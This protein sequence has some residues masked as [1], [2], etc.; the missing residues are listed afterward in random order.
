MNAINRSTVILAA[1]VLTGASYGQATSNYT[2]TR[3][4]VRDNPGVLGQSYGDLNYS[5]VDFRHSAA[6]AYDLGASANLPIAPGIDAGLG[7]QYYRQSDSYDP[8]A[9]RSYD[10]R[11]HM[12][13]ANANFFAPTRGAKP[14]IGGLVGYEWTH[15]SLRRLRTYDNQWV[16]GA[17]GG[18]E[19]PVGLFAF[20]PHVGYTDTMHSGSTGSWHYGAEAHHWFSET[21][22]AYV[23][24]TFHDPNRNG[25]P[26]AWTYTAGLRM[27]Y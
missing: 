17:T 15:G 10:Y 22:G 23:D 4:S 16:W 14:F 3:P 24:A 18:V 25:G 20:T 5:W 2:S 1:L 21:V 9:G 27:R 26:E 19:V 7:Y 11:Y 8:F 13:G 6:K 12:L